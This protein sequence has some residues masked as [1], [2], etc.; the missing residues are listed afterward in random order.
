ML[1]ERSRRTINAIVGASS[2]DDMSLTCCKILNGC[3]LQPTEEPVHGRAEPNRY[4]NVSERMNGIERK[5]LSQ[6]KCKRGNGRAGVDQGHRRD[7]SK[8]NGRHN[9]RSAQPFDAQ[10]ALLID[11]HLRTENGN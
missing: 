10:N 1:K 6:Q 5:A 2:M 11:G 4:G 9:R 8:Q 7:E 3:I